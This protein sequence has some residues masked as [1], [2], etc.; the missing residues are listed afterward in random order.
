[1]IATAVSEIDAL[2]AENAALRDEL[3]TLQ[4][5]HVGEVMAHN[6]ELL[7]EVTRLRAENQRLQGGKSHG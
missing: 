7:G 6:D 1:M 5:A 4:Q 2:R 3:E